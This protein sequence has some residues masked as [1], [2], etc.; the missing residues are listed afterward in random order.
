M[1]GPRR[2]CGAS[3]FK[4]FMFAKPKKHIF[5][6]NCM[7]PV[8][9]SLSG[10]TQHENRSPKIRQ[11]ITDFNNLGSIDILGNGP[12]PYALAS[13]TPEAHAEVAGSVESPSSDFTTLVQ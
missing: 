2:V 11:V 8:I 5:L 6:A 1:L 13:P 9:F 3:V 7:L 4:S 10:C 12:R